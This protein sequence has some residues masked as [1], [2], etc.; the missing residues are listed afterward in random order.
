MIVRY[1]RDKITVDNFRDLKPSDWNKSIPRLKSIVS[2]M[3]GVQDKNNTGMTSKELK[4]VV[5][6]L[7][8]RLLDEAENYNHKVVSVTFAGYEDVYNFEVEKYHNYPL[9]CGIISHNCISEIEEMDRVKSQAKDVFRGI[10][11]RMHSRFERGEGFLE[12][13]HLV[14][15]CSAKYQEGFQAQLMSEARKDP[16]KKTLLIERSIWAVL[17]E[18]GKLELKSDKTFDLFVGGSGGRE[19]CILIPGRHYNYPESLIIKVP[20]DYRQH[21]E[22]D[23]YGAVRDLAGVCTIN[24][25]KFFSQIQLLL[26]AM[27]AD[28]VGTLE[29]DVNPCYVDVVELDFDDPDDSIIKHIDMSKLDKNAAYYLHVDIGVSH[30]KTGISLTRTS[31]ERL[32]NKISPTLERS[33]VQDIVFR[34]DLVLAVAPKPGKEVPIAKLRNFVVELRH[35]GIRVVAVSCDQYQ[36]TQFLQEMKDQGIAAELVSVDRCRDQYDFFQ[37]LIVERRWT[38]P[39][40]PILEREFLGVVDNGTKIVLPEPNE[41]DKSIRPSKD[42]SDSVVG[43]VWLCKLKN[44]SNAGSIALENYVEAMRKTEKRLDLQDAIFDLGMRNRQKGFFRR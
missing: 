28:K 27:T 41:I 33:T 39:Y 10:Q 8:P 12:P 6:E 34:T 31:G 20:E 7:F 26:E 2:V 25:H 44:N 36:S 14:V 30:C 13:G 21:F 42:M 1:G 40:H 32:V 18:A 15:D 22:Q 17:V 16:L 35:R 38:G 37:N 4:G 24:I 29:E 3:G 23:I 9:N 19:P 11:R 5:I 43:S